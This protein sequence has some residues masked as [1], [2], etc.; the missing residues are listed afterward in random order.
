MSENKPQQLAD[1]NMK[2][3]VFTVGWEPYFIDSL[4]A[5]IEKHT[6]FDF[7]HGLVGDAS[8]ISYAQ[9]Q[10]PQLKFV[11][12]SKTKEDP[13]PAPDHELLASLEGVGI[14]TVKSMVQGDPY[15]RHRSE[16]ESLG[17]ATLL[18]RS[19]QKNIKKLQPNVV[20]ASFD[21]IHSGISL[22]VAK[23]LGIPWVAMAFPVIPDNLTGFC[24]GLTPNMIVPILRP[25]DDGLKRD[26]K[27]IIQN[28]RCG[29]QRVI[30][31]RAPVS[32][33]N[34]VQQYILHG[35]NFINR[36][37]KR[38]VHG[39]DRFT[40]PTLWERTRD[41]VR[42]SIN[43]F[44]LPSG[45]MLSVPPSGRYVY[46]PFHM[47]PESMVDTWA[48]FYQDQISFITQLSLS[49][50]ADVELVVKL[51]FSD[52]ANYSRS[53]LQRLM[54]RHHVRV[55]SPFVPSLPFLERASLVVGI[56]GTSNLEAALRGKPV[57]I[58]G[59]SPYQHFPRT[60]R[61]KRPDELY[62]QIRRM[63]AL[64]HPTEE[65]IVDA[66]AA[67]MAR[68]MSG[69]INDWGRPIKPEELGQFVNCFHAL[70]SYVEDP[71]NRASYRHL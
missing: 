64:P 20:L 67:Y 69:R 62:E 12:L 30:A 21:C 34:W 44:F 10:F 4:L 56:T 47:S 25:V 70:R 65:E 61:A 42:R 1:D 50:P 2:F 43:S 9:K 52:P 26:A 41:I 27:A 15:I 32:F 38:N 16:R 7:I 58:F 14:P 22:A 54:H 51:H 48:P 59:D 6:G 60:E 17:Y 24:F 13:L 23:S 37:L 57:L 11:A 36:V 35:S 18:A 46:F 8:R 40:A 5:P 45:S 19:I 63:L 49:M 33:K 71:V 31:Y 29:G 3:K 66:Y 55:A 53:Q 28:V 39:V 68:Y